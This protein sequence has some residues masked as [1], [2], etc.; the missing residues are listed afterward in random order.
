MS[1]DG[2]EEPS[3]G[4]PALQ[5]CPSLSR[6]RT[7]CTFCLRHHGATGPCQGVSTVRTDAG[8][9]VGV[10]GEAKA[11]LCLLLGICMGK[12]QGC[13]HRESPRQ[14]PLMPCRVLHLHQ[15]RLQED[16]E[17]LFAQAGSNFKAAPLFPLKWER[18]LSRTPI[19][20]GK[21]L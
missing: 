12:K 20:L 15:G 18:S 6:P 3:A 1:A 16:A 2:G 14:P 10:G 21:K 9:S 7:V 13:A 11:P 17:L 8:C 19:T 5:L 4:D